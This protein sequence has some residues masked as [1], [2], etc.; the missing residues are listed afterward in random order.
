MIR[1]YNYRTGEIVHSD[2][3]AHFGTKG[4][5]WY[6]RR[7][8][9]EDG[10][11]TPLGREHYGIGMAKNRSKIAKLETKNAKIER[12]A[13]RRFFK[14]D[15]E[16]AARLEAKNNLKIAKLN[17]KNTKMEQALAK[18]DEKKAKLESE[19]ERIAAK[20]KERQLNGEG[21]T[22]TEDVRALQED[23]H[24]MLHNTHSMSDM[25]IMM[26]ENKT[27][28][29]AAKMVSDK[30]NNAKK[31]DDAE[32]RKD[33]E[34]AASVITEVADPD[35]KKKYNEMND[36]I[37]DYIRGKAM[38]KLGQ[39]LSD[40]DDPLGLEADYKRDLSEEKSVRQRKQLES[41]HDSWSNFEKK[42]KN[43]EERPEDKMTEKHLNELNRRME[44]NDV[45]P[46]KTH[47]SDSYKKYEEVQRNYQTAL[48]RLNPIK[49]KKLREE[50]H[51]ALDEARRTNKDYQDVVMD[52]ASEYINSNMPKAQRE[53]ARAYVWEYLGNDW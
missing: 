49:T 46:A 17:Q 12:K 18:D 53:A 7:Y 20:L 52:V 36:L 10:T 34:E 40:S 25:D 43:W 24:E 19:R 31:F 30:W 5:H 37:A 9:Y 14:M 48:K 26:Q 39:K 29:S 23:L 38:N 2:E 6:D 16:K 41:Y 13:T 22:E 15:P 45:E 21:I 42:K 33:V 32:F 47:A 3:L 50:L 8:Q 1:L 51:E 44:S 28:N 35:G 27:I 4:M 11:Y